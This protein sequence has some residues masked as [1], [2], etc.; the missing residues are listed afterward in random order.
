MARKRSSSGAALF[1]ETKPLKFDQKLVLLQWML[2]L[3]DK[4]SFEQLAEP[5]KSAELEGLNE[6]NN[7]KFLA[8]FRALWEL[9]EFPGDV[10]L[11]YDQNIVKHTLK[12]NERRSEPIRWKYFQWLS[13]LFAEVYLGRFFRDPN[14]L[15]ADLNDFVARFNAD[16]LDKDKIPPYELADLRKVAFWNATGSGKTLLMHANILQYRHYLDLHGKGRELNRIILLTPNEGLSRQHL[17][18]FHAAGLDA[19]VFSKDGK[20]LFAGKTIEIID[21]HKLRE[22]MGDKTVAIDAFEGNNL[23][24]VDEGHRGSS[25]KEAGRWMDARR[26]LCEQGFSFEYS[27]TFGQ[28]MKASGNKALE[29]EYAK[30]ILFDYSY[31]YFYRDGFGKD[32]RIL[33]LADDSD[34]DKRRLYL[35]ACLLAFYQQQRLYR[36]KPA[37]FRPFLLE[38]PLWVF[39]GGSVN[40]VRSENKK[41]VSDVVDILLFL[42]E[43]VTEKRHTIDLLDRLLSGKPGLL[44]QRGNEIF[45]T[46]FGYLSLARQDGEALYA[47]ILKLLFNSSNQAKLHV[48]N[49]KGTDG[50]IALRLGENDAFGLINVGDASALCKLCDEHPDFLA[51]DEKEFSGS[52][53]ASLSA[54]A[55]TVH[56]LI[57]SKK[58]TEGWNSWRVSTMGLMN[59]GK[60]E[61]SE[62]IQLF[63]RGVRLKGFGM[64][65]KRSSRTDGIPK[66][67]HINL[68]ET[69]NIFGI[70]AP[71]MQQFKEYLEDE[72]LPPNEERIEFILPVVKNL[73]GKKLTGI[74][75]KEGVDFKRQGTKPTLDEPTQFMLKHPVTL[76]W[77]P[78]IQAQQSKGVVGTT[79]LSCAEEGRFEEKH[80]AFMDVDAMYFELQHF[81]NERAWYNLNLPRESVM[82]LLRNHN[83]YR[84]YIPLSEME[85]T[86]FDRVRRWEEIAVALLKKY[87]DRFYKHKKQEWEADHL[88]YH[89]LREDDPNF[90]Q[91]YRLLI[92][93][94]ADSIKQGLLDLKEE[95]NKKTVRDKLEV[96]NLTAYWFGN[97]LYQPLLH[98][99]KSQLIEVSPVSLNDGERDFVLDLKKFHDQQ[100]N[101]FFKERELF[102]LR[103]VSKRGIGFFEAGNFYPDFILWLLV[104]KKQYVTFVDPKGLRQLDEGSSN[105]K[106]QFYRT[107]KDI[108]ARLA[109]PA[110]I[111]NS[112]IVSPTPYQNIPM[113]GDGMSKA[114]LQS[115]H[116]L[117]QKDDTDT[118]IKTL[119]TKVVANA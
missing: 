32:Y 99:S 72:G 31:K 95:I 96:G 80:L 44:D 109:E 21:I 53:F 87:I 1:P 9:E 33:N 63:G 90:V 46:A 25:G 74:R 76:N 73:G 61:G 58:F 35:T 91:E 51:V 106:A 78:K 105:P 50:E 52:L 86:R 107:I 117:F 48:L 19:E 26:R 6:D 102:L 5:F 59:V 20:S 23:V 94:S 38:D 42:A 104:G 49:L 115:C 119:L 65:L 41:K 79:E 82:K 55:S 114:E 4:K 108:E 24:L 112:F 103:N 30:C 39:V 54:A 85:F 101:E 93:E 56:I 2:G 34:E 81:K 113:W 15:L 97:H 7:H 60:S 45:A 12:L 47:D 71:Y 29:Q 40:A 27:A 110:V 3:F 111:L 116:V 92:E 68:L 16:K 43:F 75:L 88:E 62:V 28:A 14:K 70:R 84:L 69:L 66:P 83:W 13:L 17:A 89:E 57:G 22:D 118:Y 36:D 10:L 64:C 8:V 98:L 11:G 18:E 67:P 77:Y 100:K 37:E